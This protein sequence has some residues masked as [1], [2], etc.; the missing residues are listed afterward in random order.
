MFSRAV[1]VMALGR[2]GP[3]RGH[4][5][6]LV[7]SVRCARA[8]RWA[9]SRCNS[10]ATGPQSIVQLTEGTKISRQ[11]I[12]KHLHALA[13]AGLAYSTRD[14]RERI[15]QLQTERLHDVRIYLHQISAQW[16]DT[17]ERLRA[18]WNTTSVEGQSLS[19]VTQQ[20]I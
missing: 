17:I 7:A 5:L 2:I 1:D 20:Q 16:D 10:T 11:T 12:T 15:W 19:T 13:E 8:E 3:A 4:E 18:S 14:R 9:R 6:E